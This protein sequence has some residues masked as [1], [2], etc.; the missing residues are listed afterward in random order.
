MKRKLTWLNTTTLTLGFAFFYLPILL[1]ILFSFNEG[2]LVTVWTGFST[3]WYVE[4]FRNEEMLDAAWLTARIAFL[5]AS[6][7]V[8]LGTMAAIIL[9]RM[10]RF[11][12]RTAFS[13]M[14]FAPLVMPEVITGL[15]LLLLFVALNVSRGFW[16]ITLAHITFNMAFVSV[17]VSSRLVTFDRSL[18]EAAYDLGCSAASAFRQVTL[19]IIMPAIISAWLLAFVSSL[20]DLVIA[21]FTS[22]PGATTLP[23]KLYSSIRRGVTPEINALSTLLIGIVVMGVV[24]AAILEKRRLARQL[25]DEQMALAQS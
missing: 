3:R 23:M 20:D 5:S 9:V 24:V 4:V 19:P 18:E 1:L 11:R 6:I 8:V 25:K 17:I 12:G 16:T 21:S 2:R 10:G 14:V 15:S 22:G 7:S 13:G